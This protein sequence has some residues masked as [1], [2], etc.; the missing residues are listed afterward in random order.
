MQLS[1]FSRDSRLP[2]GLEEIVTEIERKKVS[3]SLNDKIGLTEDVLVIPFNIGFLLCTQ[4]GIFYVDEIDTLKALSTGCDFSKFESSRV[5][6]LFQHGLVS[7]YSGKRFKEV[8][9]PELHWSKYHNDSFV[10]FSMVP[11]AVELN[12]TNVCNFYCIHC[13]KNSGADHKSEE[14]PTEQVIS[15]IDECLQVGIPE[16]RFMGGEPLAH[17]GFFRFIQYARENGIFQLKLSTNAW[18]I[19]AEK[20]KQLTKYFDS[21]QIS[22]HGASPEMH[23]SVVKKEGAWKQAKRATKLLNENGVKV[24]IGF[25]V[26]RKNADD[27]SKM[28]QLA[29]DWD[30]DSLGFLCLIPQGRGSNLT[31]WTKN[32]IFKIGDRIRELKAVSEF[33]LNLDVAGFPPIDVL[34]N[35]NTVYGCEAGKALMAVDPN[36]KV[37]SCGILDN[38]SGFRIGERPLL[39]IWHSSYFVALRK[40]LSCNDCNYGSI[41]WGPCK[42][43]EKTT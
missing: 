12:I 13:S 42:F 24:N 30:A 28:F 10:L 37:K 22:V 1:I 20:A 11:L 15:V 14:L 43:L 40:Q 18:L 41:C 33:S 4:R 26:M 16:L 19:T 6:Q 23:D 27:L 36:G 31:E 3:F 21:I 34:K 9:V 2:C 29:M 8:K 38:S 17:P 32:E 25:S 35:N 39:E 5:E 7:M